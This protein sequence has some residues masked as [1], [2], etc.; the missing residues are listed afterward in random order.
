MAP[1]FNRGIRAERIFGFTNG[2]APG[3]LLTD[4]DIVID[5]IVIVRAAVFTPTSLSVAPLKLE[6]V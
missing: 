4:T 5:G 1:R 6:T 3:F 2:G